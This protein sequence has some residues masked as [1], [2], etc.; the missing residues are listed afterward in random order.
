LKPNGVII[1]QATNRFVDLMPAIAK[2]AEA[3]GMTAVH[4]SDSPDA[5]TGADYWTSSTDQVIVTRNPKILQHPR[6]T[7][8]GKT[9]QAPADF[10]IWTDDFYNMLRVLK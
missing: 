4:I 1:F 10:R 3:Y 2:L 6:I 8:T 9:L 7:E 5:T